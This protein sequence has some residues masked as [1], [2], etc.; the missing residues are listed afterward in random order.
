MRLVVARCFWKKSRSIYD[1]RVAEA[2][3][4][5]I[6]VDNAVMR[7]EV[8]AFVSIIIHSLFWWHWNL[9][10][11]L[12]HCRWSFFPHIHSYYFVSF[13]FYFEENAMK[14]NTSDHCVD[15]GEWDVDEHSAVAVTVACGIR[16]FPEMDFRV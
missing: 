12:L 9:Q 1:G 4:P 6:A 16:T 15:D 7:D 8:N 11:L 2:V 13:N 3:E 10:T 14:A 5:S